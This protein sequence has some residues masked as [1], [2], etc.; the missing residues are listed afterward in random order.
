MR[1]IVHGVH[2][3]GIPLKEPFMKMSFSVAAV[4]LLLATAGIVITPF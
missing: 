1:G 3:N 4:G 2:L